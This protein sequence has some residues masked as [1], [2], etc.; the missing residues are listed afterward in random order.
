MGK[1][2]NDDSVKTGKKWSWN[3]TIKK[4]KK[5]IHTKKELHTIEKKKV[6]NSTIETKFDKFG[7]K[8][9]RFETSN[10]FDEEKV[11]N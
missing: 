10:K 4:S 2:I 9:S 3:L 1:K 5:I 11:I 6:K 7:N 8:V